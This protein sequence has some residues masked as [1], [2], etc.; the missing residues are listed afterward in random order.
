MSG[1]ADVADDISP[2]GANRVYDCFLY[3]G[4]A[5][6]VEI[7]FHELWDAVDVFVIV[8]RA[9][10]GGA[11]RNKFSWNPRSPRFAK[12]AKKVRHVVVEKFANDDEGASPPG[13]RGDAILRGATDAAADDIILISDAEEIPSLEAVREVRRDETAALWGL[14]LALHAY[15]LDYRNV[16]GPLS[17]LVWNIAARR[18][19]L[20]SS[21]PEALRLAIRRGNVEARSIPSAGWHFRSLGRTRGR[22]RQGFF[23]LEFPDL[24]VPESADPVRLVKTTADPFGQNASRWG[25]STET[26]LPECLWEDGV[27][28][29][30][31]LAPR[32][33]FDLWRRRAAVAARSSV[34]ARLD[35]MV[36]C[37]YLYSE[38]EAE[39]RR[40]FDLDGRGGKGVPF[41]LWHDAKRIGPEKAFEHCW[42]LFPE[43]D[44][45]IVH[46]DMAPRPGQ[47]TRDWY[48]RLCAYRGQLDDAG[49]IACDLLYPYREGETP[50]VQSAGGGYGGGDIK[51][52]YDF[53][54]DSP[55][56]GMDMSGVR[57]ADW[58]TFGGVL[59]LRETIRACGA[60][61]PRYNWAYYM[62]V[63]YSLEARLKGFKLYQVPLNLVHEE[64]RTT[65]G[66][67]QADR[68]LEENIH[69]NKARLLEKWEKFEPLLPTHFDLKAFA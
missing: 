19:E 16:S 6:A 34:P 12:F 64:S 35:P 32:G 8:E 24:C 3:D 14:Q 30:L 53:P 65:R 50:I 29:P 1:I 37:P 4:E 49:M 15:Y 52:I 44:I 40:K 48:E 33:I 41:H 11:S 69:R 31:L 60:F 51:Q 39:I 28:N 36:I 46:S 68:S 56:A 63:D 54:L 38:E 66:L 47:S 2:E 18:R 20:D 57:K 21:T 61:D 62:D 25:K 26:T 13:W 10:A 67:L 5:D 45:I 43:Q 23:E 27:P 17:D 58:V 7:R 42:S 59:I 9:K 22:Q 55:P